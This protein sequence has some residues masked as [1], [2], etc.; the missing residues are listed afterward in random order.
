MTRLKSQIQEAASRNQRWGDEACRLRQSIA[1]IKS[2]IDAEE[3][4]EDGEACHLEQDVAEIENVKM[5][6]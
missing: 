6:E 4:N 5:D 3:Q 1:E 2:K